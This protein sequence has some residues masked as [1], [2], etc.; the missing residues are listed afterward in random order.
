[1]FCGRSP[2]LAVPRGGERSAR[3]EGSWGA[4]IAVWRKAVVASSG[5][6]NCF[7]CASPRRHTWPASRK[8]AL[9]IRTTVEIGLRRLRKASASHRLRRAAVEQRSRARRMRCGIG[10]S[11][12]RR[13]RQMGSH[14]DVCTPSFRSLVVRGACPVGPTARPRLAVGAGT[15]RIRGPSLFLSAAWWAGS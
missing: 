9:R 14:I 2:S 15:N 10:G 8:F 1:M 11:A 13:A 12:D 7:N 5:I 4:A 6:F 3:I